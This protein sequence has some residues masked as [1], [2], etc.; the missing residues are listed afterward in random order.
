[1]QKYALQEHTGI[2]STAGQFVHERDY[3]TPGGV[4]LHHSFL[5]E[6]KKGRKEERKERRKKES[7]EERKKA[8]K[9]E[10]KK[11]IRW[12]GLQYARKNN[13]NAENF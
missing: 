3:P 2:Y 1:M 10:R 12:E 6:R 9:K 7:K 8:R 4:T 13:K 5:K 11:E